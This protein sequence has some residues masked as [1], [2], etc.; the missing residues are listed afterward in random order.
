MKRN[1]PKPLVRE[2]SVETGANGEETREQIAVAAYY[3]AE[4]R[5]FTPGFELEDWLESE[6]ELGPQEGAAAGR[7]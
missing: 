1:R 6:R 4:G 3:K 2:E 7:R 5:G